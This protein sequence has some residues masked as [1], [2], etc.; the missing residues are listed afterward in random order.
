MMLLGN[1]F[2]YGNANPIYT[3]PITALL[4]SSVLLVTARIH[5]LGMCKCNLGSYRNMLVFLCRIIADLGFV[6]WAVLIDET[7]ENF[8]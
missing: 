7:H 8:G 6:I 3:Y 5:N 2:E 1:T 4:S